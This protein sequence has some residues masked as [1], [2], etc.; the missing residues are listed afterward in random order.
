[1]ARPGIPRHTT[2]SAIKKRALGVLVVKD[3]FDAC[4]PARGFLYGDFCAYVAEYQGAP[5]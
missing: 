2:E 3:L 5:I 1:M 4:T